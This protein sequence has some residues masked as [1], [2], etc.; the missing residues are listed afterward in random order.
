MT[1]RNV[2]H[3]SLNY[4]DAYKFCYTLDPRARLMEVHTEEQM[5]FLTLLLSTVLTTKSSYNE[6]SRS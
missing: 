4:E 3:E 1:N 5:D 2:T 6:V